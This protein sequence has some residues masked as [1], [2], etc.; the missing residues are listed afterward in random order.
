MTDFNCEIFKAASK[1]MLYTP[2]F[3]TL[4]NEILFQ[5]HRPSQRQAKSKKQLQA[6]ERGALGLLLVGY[7]IKGCIYS[8]VYF[9]IIC[10]CFGISVLF[11]LLCPLLPFI[12]PAILIILLIATAVSVVVPL[13][14]TLTGGG[15]ENVVLVDP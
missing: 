1:T 14:V 6:E 15:S 4:E 3:E 11:L 2:D 5:S 10:L 8:Y 7:L 12:I 9:K 13:V